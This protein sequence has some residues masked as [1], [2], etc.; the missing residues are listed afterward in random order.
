MLPK[1]TA[2]PM[3]AIRKPNLED[4]TDGLTD[5]ILPAKEFQGYFVDEGLFRMFVTLRHKAARHIQNFVHFFHY[6]SSHALHVPGQYIVS[7][8][9][10][11]LNSLIK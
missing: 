6:R 10:P 3:D 7:V 9:T 2:N 1:P 8:A 4:Q 5:I 11:P